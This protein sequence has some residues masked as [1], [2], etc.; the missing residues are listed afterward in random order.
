MGA[1]CI[2]KE[3]R[4]SL[5]L[6][7]PLNRVEQPPCAPAAHSGLLVL[8]RHDFHAVPSVLIGCIRNAFSIQIRDKAIQ[9]LFPMGA[10]P[11]TV[12][13]P[14]NKRRADSIIYTNKYAPRYASLQF[15]IT[16]TPQRPDSRTIIRAVNTGRNVASL[17]S[18]SIAS[19]FL[20]FAKQT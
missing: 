19:V 20:L 4:S 11:L 9:S 10:E 12:S 2:K 15:R 18:S 8:R 16:E 1:F 17:M 5:F 7:Y 14:F 6:M 13:K 3:S